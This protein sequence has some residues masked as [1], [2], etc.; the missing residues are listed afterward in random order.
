MKRDGHDQIMIEQSI[1]D[2]I[3]SLNHRYCVIM[4]ESSSILEHLES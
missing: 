1:H 2:P 3:D 4:L